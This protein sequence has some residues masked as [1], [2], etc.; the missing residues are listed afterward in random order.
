MHANIPTPKLP[1]RSNLDAADRGDAEIENSEVA[2][3]ARTRLEERLRQDFVAR[4]RHQDSE[5]K[6]G[7]RESATLVD[8]RRQ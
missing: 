8:W 3:S 5:E 4:V 1:A 7:D 2:L 6:S